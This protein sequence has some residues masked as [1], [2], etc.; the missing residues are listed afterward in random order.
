MR[1]FMATICAFTFSCLLVACSGPQKRTTTS[2]HPEPEPQMS[3]TVQS[4][5]T[6]WEDEPEAVEALSELAEH[7]RQHS[8]CF[9]KC[10][11][12]WK[13]GDRRV[14]TRECSELQCGPYHHT[15]ES[16]K[17]SQHHAEIDPCEER[18]MDDCSRGLDEDRHF[19]W[20]SC[21][22]QCKPCSQRESRPSSSPHY[23]ESRPSSPPPRAPP[24]A[25]PQGWPT[26]RARAIVR[27]CGLGFMHEDSKTKRY[28]RL[29]DITLSMLRSKGEETT[30]DALQSWRTPGL[31][32]DQREAMK[33]CNSFPKWCAGISAGI[34][35]S[36]QTSVPPK[37]AKEL[38]ELIH[39]REVADL[40]RQRQ[41]NFETCKRECHRSKPSATYKHCRLVCGASN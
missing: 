35:N 1:L 31:S 30:L 32:Y 20:V 19:D 26:M 10:V 39:R 14:S 6:L 21:A 3:T 17:R 12:T 27:G 8:E 15:E 11:A 7:H 16:L 40:E 4:S 24:E 37:I 38:T 5:E 25:A 28:C 36:T 9:Q 33:L 2:G 18:C 22:A 41:A 23:A 34:I 13:S 29:I